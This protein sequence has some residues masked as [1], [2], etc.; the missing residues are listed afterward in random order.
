MKNKTCGNC[1]WFRRHVGET[2]ES[3]KGW[4][5]LNP[6]WVKKIENTPRC[7]HWKRGK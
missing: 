6:E 2:H 4:C 1:K 5:V 3:D 7:S